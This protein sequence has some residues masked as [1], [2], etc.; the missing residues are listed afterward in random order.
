MSFTFVEVP[1][2]SSVFRGVDEVELSDVSYKLTDGYTSVLGGTNKRPGYSKAIQVLEDTVGV[3][4]SDIMGLYWW[5]QKELL[6]VAARQELYF[7]SYINDTLINTFIGSPGGLA[8]NANQPVT[9]DSNDTYVFAV[10]EG[11]IWYSDGVSIFNSVT[12]GNPAGFTHIALLDGYLIGNEK[13]STRVRYSE[14]LTPL[15]WSAEFFSAIGNSDNILSLVVHNREIFC[16]GAETTEIWENDGTTPFS[17]ISGG[18][19]EVGTIAPYS[20]IK[21]ENSIIWLNDKKRFVE[22][23]GKEIKYISSGYDKDIQ[24]FSNCSDCIG[25]KIE[26]EGQLLLVFTFKTDRRTLIYN[27]LQDEWC[28]W[29]TFLPESNTRKEWQGFFHAFSPKWNLYFVASPSSPYLYFLG[30]EH[31]TDDGTPIVLERVTGHLDWK[32][33][34]RKR[35]R[36]LHLRIKRGSGELSPTVPQMMVRW[37]DDNKNWSQ[38]KYIDLGN[39][40][41]TEISRRILVSGVFN[42]RQFEFKVSDNVPVVF[43]QAQLE[44]EELSL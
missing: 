29:S 25:S 37:K 22:Y 16:I 32:L 7:F 18:F 3:A 33:P 17:R 4:V 39:S 26:I 15:T 34:R 8:L 9:F 38:E 27:Y 31:L 6:V 36:Y 42:T 40:G 14:P 10:I 21:T 19:L 2:S 23:N 43:T 35:A 13:G 12:T 44:I 41:E 11:S 1:I 5:G 24:G 30:K 28:E 20:V